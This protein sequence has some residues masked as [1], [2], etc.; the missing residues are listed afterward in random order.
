MPPK[1]SEMNH[2]A[3][4]DRASDLLLEWC[5]GFQ[6]TALFAGHFHRH[7][8]SVYGQTRVIVTG[9]GGGSFRPGGESKPTHYIQAQVTDGV[10]TTEEIRIPQSDW[11]FS[12]MTYSLTVIIA[13]FRWLG[14]SGFLSLFLVSLVIFL[15]RERS[16]RRRSYHCT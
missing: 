5:D 16:G 8:E 6:V 11:W 9:G 3:I 12:L 7:I 15:W 13:R 1:L 4:S 2:R 10:L 14:V